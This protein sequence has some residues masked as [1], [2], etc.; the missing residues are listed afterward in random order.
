M[1][2]IGR[3]WQIATPQAEPGEDFS[4]SVLLPDGGLEWQGALLQALQLLANVNTWVQVEETDLTPAAAAAHWA[5]VLWEFQ[6][7]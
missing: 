7:E 6:Y 4:R 3:A 5:R 1:T 2:V